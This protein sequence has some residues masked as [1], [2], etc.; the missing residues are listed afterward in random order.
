M[1]KKRRERERRYCYRLDL[2]YV[3]NVGEMETWGK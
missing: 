2:E 3:C 1:R